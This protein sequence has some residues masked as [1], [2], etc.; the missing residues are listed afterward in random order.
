MEG[1]TGNTTNQIGTSTKMVQLNEATFC[2]LL[3]KA[4]PASSEIALPAAVYTGNSS[5]AVFLN[6]NAMI[7]SEQ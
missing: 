6:E 1:A 3:E 2:S 7:L 4:F 5:C